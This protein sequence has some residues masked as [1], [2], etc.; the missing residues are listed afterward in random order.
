MIDTRHRAVPAQAAKTRVLKVTPVTRAVRMAL[1][2]TTLAFAGTGAAFAGT[3]ASAGTNTIECTGSFTDTVTFPD[4]DLTLVLGDGVPTSVTPAVGDMGVDASWPGRATVVSYADIITDSA[5][6][7]HAD[8]SGAAHIT[9]HG[10][11]TTY[12][13]VDGVQAVDIVAGGNASFTN[14]GDVQA[15]GYAAYDV[16]AVRVESD[17]C[18][19]EVTVDNEAGGVISAIALGGGDA[20]GVYGYSTTGDISITNDGDVLAYSAYGLADGIFASG[21]DVA[22][23]NGGN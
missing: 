18:G 9:N 14:T 12:V 17:G 21:V 2:A 15:Y 7:I 20:I 5:D 8:S 11:V 10:S 23:A 19:C 16:T 4:A 3:C 6:G 1:A 13:G 22:V